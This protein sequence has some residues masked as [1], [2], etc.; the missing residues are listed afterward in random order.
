[1]FRGEGQ[2]EREGRR[3]TVT[4]YLRYAAETAFQLPCR[5][6]RTRPKRA[7]FNE[8]ANF[9]STSTARNSFRETNAKCSRA[10]PRARTARVVLLVEEE[11]NGRERGGMTIK[12]HRRRI[13]ERLLC[14]SVVKPYEG[15]PSY[16][17]VAAP[18]LVISPFPSSTSTG[19]CR[20][21]KYS[22]FLPGYCT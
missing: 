2:R 14:R 20:R 1:M 19:P 10:A 22:G 7:D 4:F 17:L 16:P 3:G 15:P 21:N 18:L 9:T 13:T 11:G 8:I 12:R 5:N 6:A